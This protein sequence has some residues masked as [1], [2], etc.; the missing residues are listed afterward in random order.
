MRRFLED[1][2]AS[3]EVARVLYGA[4]VALALI[5]A[6]EDHPPT[7]G[8]TVAALL[9]TGVAVGLA[10][11][12]AELVAAEART[13]QPIHRERIKEF[14]EDAAAVAFGA[15]FPAVYFILAAA[16]AMHTHTAFQIAK[17]SGVGLI[18]VYGFMG[19]RLSGAGPVRA[20][21]QTLV[22]G[23]IGVGLIVL[24]SLTH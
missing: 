12:Y 9:G 5:V 19:A 8:E 7:A 4:I 21:S 16:G 23:L 24:K 3:G 11:L 18:C 2:L 14:S 22:V 6:L 10:E 1:H 17:W 13:R 20:I 15:A